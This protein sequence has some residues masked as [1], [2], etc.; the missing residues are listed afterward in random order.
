[1]KTIVLIACS[2]RKQTCRCKA[3]DLYTGPL[4]IQSLKYAKKRKPYKIYV[5]SAKHH[6]LS[7]DKEIEPYDCTL[8]GMS[9]SEVR[10][11][12]D[13]VLKQLRSTS[14]MKQTNYVLLAGSKY[15]ESLLELERIK[16]PEIP[17]KGLRYGEQLRRLKEL[18]SD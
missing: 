7:L 3:Q 12:S 17:L 9:A 8:K 5:L 11:W 2:K 14:D 6:L 15:R 13:K 4:F 1:M 16:D 10:T 18:T